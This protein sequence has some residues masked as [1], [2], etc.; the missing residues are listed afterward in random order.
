MPLSQDT[1][2]EYKVRWD[3][4]NDRQTN[5]L[6]SMEGIEMEWSTVPVLF[7]F[8]THNYFIAHFALVA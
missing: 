8:K 2:L 3:K 4:Q 6:Y 1:Y 5:D 7:F